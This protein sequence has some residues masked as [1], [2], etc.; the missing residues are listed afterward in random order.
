MKTL[1]IRLLGVLALGLGGLGSSHAAYNATPD[2][3]ECANRV[4]GTFVHGRIPSGCDVATF[5]PDSFVRGNYGGTV[6]NDAAYNTA[7]G[8]DPISVAE[9][10]R[11]MQ[12]M[13]PV[14]RD[15]SQRYL[16]ARKPGVQERELQ[17]FQRG[18][19]ALL[20][21][22]S[23]W[24]HYRDAQTATG[25]P[26][27]LKM[28]RGDNGHGHGMMQVDD[29]YHFLPLQ[30]GKGWNMMQNF[31]YAIDIYYDAWQKAP[32]SCLGG[33][34]S[35]DDEYWR[36][37][38]RS[39]WSAYNGGPTRVCRWQN[40]ADANVAKDNG[41]RDNYDLRRWLT[42]VADLNKPASIDVACLMDNGA[43]CPQ[44][45]GAPLGPNRLMKLG[46][47]ACVLVGETLECV[48]TVGDASCL[49]G[50]SSF[51]ERVIATIYAV[52]VTG[53]MRVDHNRHQIC[54]AFVPGL[55]SLG[56]A[57]TTLAPLALRSSIDGM[58][59]GQAPAGTYQVLD[60][61]V[62]GVAAKQRFYRIRATLNGVLTDGW[63]DAGAAAT[64][65]SLATAAAPSGAGAL[66][67]PG[68]WVSVVPN[69]NMRATPGGALLVTIPAG[70]VVQIKELFGTAS[71][72]NLYYRIEYTHSDG[73]TREGWIFGGNLYPSSTLANW[74]LPAAAPSAQKHAHC[75]NGTRYDIHSRQ[76]MSAS[77]VYGPFT[78]AAV[79]ACL[80]SGAGAV[81]T[82]NRATVVDGVALTLPIWSKAVAAQAV[83]NGDCPRGAARSSA[84][85]FHCVEN[86]SRDGVLQTDV[87]GPFS[88]AMVSACLASQGNAG[89]CRSNRWPATVFLAQQP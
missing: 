16:N 36:S 70:R 65:A 44:P 42:D 13:Y 34:I 72:N 17:A 77:S 4:G 47:S 41:Y 74:V 5:G 35:G 43:Q 63:I 80:D 71:A 85:R 62:S 8:S 57:I 9:R 46:N 86:V 7:N 79:Q 15:A 73:V 11:Y 82:A 2:F 38:A 1:A 32:A 81:C 66:P 28:I 67:Y 19:F 30:E 53:R 51:D 55:Q 68:D 59:L 31:S 3:W 21:Q 50:R 33:A 75:P 54:R 29:R 10:K 20:R 39:A 87:Y 83:G 40:T 60:F 61:A 78:A 84:H 25:Q 76:C 52:Q 56:S 58:V 48:D 89:F 26:F 88:S 24:S 27:L 45:V 18:V 12:E 22:E 37:R 64:H 14:I 49:G 69:L 6:F 23:F